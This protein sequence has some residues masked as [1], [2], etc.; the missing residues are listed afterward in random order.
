MYKIAKLIGRRMSR[1]RIGRIAFTAEASNLQ[2][3]AIFVQSEDHKRYTLVQK[4]DKHVLY[5]GRCTI[6]FDNIASEAKVITD[7][8]KSRKVNHQVH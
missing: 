6:C 1:V 3:W 2:N 4:E 7:T 8:K 5:N